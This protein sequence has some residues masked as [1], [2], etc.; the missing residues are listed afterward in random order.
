M[1]VKDRI[2]KAITQHELSYENDTFDKLIAIAYYYGAE[3]A[4]KQICDEH[5]KRAKEA[6]DRAEKVRYW[7]QAI[8]IMGDLARPIY[9][10]SYAQDM[11]IT[12]GDD[13]TNL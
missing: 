9:D 4:T 6:I 13:E 3:T 8:N 5:N 12:F 11:T 10:P 2:Y 1:K 7:K